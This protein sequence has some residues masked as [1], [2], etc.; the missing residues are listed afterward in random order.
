M[1]VK[2]IFFSYQAEGRYIGSPT[3]FVRFGGCNLNCYYCDTKKA[4]KILR[5]DIKSVDEVVNKINYFI[6]KYKP[7]FVSLTGGEPLLQE[8]SE[9]FNL[10]KRLKEKMIK[11]V[12][13]NY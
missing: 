13:D 10:L 9:I 4:K 1:I 6:K 11:K 7:E 3:V 5:K 12:K 8:E 2:E